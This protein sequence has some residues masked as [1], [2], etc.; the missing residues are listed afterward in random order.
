MKRLKGYRKIRRNEVTVFNY[1]YS[2]W[3]KLELDFNVFYAKRCVAIRGYRYNEYSPVPE[4][5]R[6]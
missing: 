1:P 6:I 3:N 2:N 5:Y 4:T